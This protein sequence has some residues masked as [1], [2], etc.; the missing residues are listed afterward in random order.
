MK[1]RAH[2]TTTKSGLSIL[3]DY[4]ILRKYQY[5]RIDGSCGMRERQQA[6]D[7]FNDD[8]D[9]PTWRLK[10]LCMRDLNGLYLLFVHFVARTCMTQATYSSEQ[11]LVFILSTRAGG[12]S[13]C[14]CIALLHDCT[15]L[16]LRHIHVLCKDIRSWQT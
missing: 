13:I 5:R 10:Y 14:T 7:E 11:V 9:V 4:F 3:E 2:V 1:C 15:C 12:A 8:P 6:M 16:L